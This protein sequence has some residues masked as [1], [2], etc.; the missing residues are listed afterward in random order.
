VNVQFM[1]D[2]RHRKGDQK[3]T[4][5]HSNA[6]DPPRLDHF[7]SFHEA[8]N[9]TQEFAPRNFVVR[10]NSSTWKRNINDG[11]RMRVCGRIG[12]YRG[13]ELPSSAFVP[14][15]RRKICKNGKKNSLDSMTSAIGK[16][17]LRSPQTIASL[18]LRFLCTISKSL[19]TNVIPLK[20]NTTI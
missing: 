4:L 9:Y 12:C 5:N 14:V 6:G 15:F 10:L 13:S 8:F 2:I 3:E 1:N 20:N 16:L 17:E 18:F 11:S 7:G 19:C